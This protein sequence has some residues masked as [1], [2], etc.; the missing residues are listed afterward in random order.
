MLSIANDSLRAEVLDPADPAD[1]TRLG[2]RFCWGGFVWQVYDPVAG[3]LLTGP[4]WPDEQPLPFNGQGIPESFRH[5]EFGN[6]RPLILEDRRGFIIGIGDVAPDADGELAVTQPCAWTITA[7]PDALEF[8]TTQT[9]NGH[10]CQ[11]S[12]RVALT[13]R[14]LT[15]STRLTN[16]GDRRLPLHWFAHPFFALTDRLL[17]CELPSDWGMA[18]NVGYALDAANRLSFKRRFEHKDDGHFEKLRIGGPLRCVLSHPRLTGLVFS[19]DFVPD[20]C[21]V[22]GNSNTWSIEPYL[23]TELAPGVSRSWMLTYEF[24]APASRELA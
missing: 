8:C 16:T 24:G 21:P 9:G 19:T 23:Q 14:T 15:S 3:P 2:T 12:R 11:L 13:G 17:T 5:A 10:A 4:E 18:E 1:R 22:W 6:G 20:M 7:A